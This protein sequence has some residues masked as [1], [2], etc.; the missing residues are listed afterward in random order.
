[1]AMK[2]LFWVGGG[3]NA[4]VIFTLSKPSLAGVGAGAEDEL[5]N[6]FTPLCTKTCRHY[7]DI[8]FPPWL[9]YMV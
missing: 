5:A 6:F 9:H 2:L 1:M 4:I 8:A 7:Q 3:L